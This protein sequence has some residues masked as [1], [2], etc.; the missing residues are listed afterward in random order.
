MNTQKA[1]L[2][3]GSP[4]GKSASEA[5]G[6]YLLNKLKEKGLSTDKLKIDK[7]VSTE[8]GQLELFDTVNQANIIIFSCPVFMSIVLRLL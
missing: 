6:M 7:L 2:F 8:R 5:L 3:I 4:K 1:V